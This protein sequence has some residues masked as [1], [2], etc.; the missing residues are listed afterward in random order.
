MGELEP[1]NPAAPADQ[2]LRFLAAEQQS[3]WALGSF[4]SELVRWGLSGLSYSAVLPLRSLR[5]Q[6]ALIGPQQA[7]PVATFSRSS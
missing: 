4:R 5:R 6:D 7:S 3:R 1:P 2:E